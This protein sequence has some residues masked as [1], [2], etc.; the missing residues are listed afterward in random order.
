ME[1]VGIN[2]FSSDFIMG[3]EHPA[4]SSVSMVDTL[5]CWMAFKDTNPRMRRKTTA[6]TQY[7]SFPHTVDIDTF[8][9]IL[10]DLASI[11]RT[12][13]PEGTES[14][15]IN[16]LL[17]ESISDIQAFLKSDYRLVPNTPCEGY[18]VY[19]YFDRLASEYVDVLI[20]ANLEI[21]H[22]KHHY[23]SILDKIQGFQFERPTEDSLSL[24][25]VALICVYSGREVVKGIVADEIAKE[26]G[27][28]SKTSGQKLYQTY[29]E[30]LRPA[31]RV[32][33]PNAETKTT[34]RNKIKLF[35]SVTNHLT[36]EARVRAQSDL[37]SLERTYE[38][39]YT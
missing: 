34:L 30:F 19:S 10:N 18:K 21:K 29:N 1:Q 32:A 2:M 38:D 17:G 13:Y 12:S 14:D 3:C 15:F 23:K 6:R 5:N 20:P 24:K 27:F 35:E 37:E 22:I 26:Y 25:V 33:I 16:H 4:R 7:I 8:L 31:D 28:T 36:G 9:N 11:Y 39:L